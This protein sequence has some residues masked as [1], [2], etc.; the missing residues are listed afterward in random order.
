MQDTTSNGGISGITYGITYGIRGQ[1][2]RNFIFSLLRKGK[3]ND[4]YLSYLTDDEAMD[5]YAQAFTNPTANYSH[6]YEMLEK[7]GDA[8]CNKV[9]VWF[10][11]NKF[12][13]LNLKPQGVML[14]S[15]I[16]HVLRSKETFANIGNTL[17]FERFISSGLMMVKGGE[18]KRVMHV[19]RNSVVED[20]FE[21][22]IGATEL[23][24][25]KRLRE[26]VGYCI[27]QNI[28]TGLLNEFPFPS[29]RYEDLF[30]PIT[31]LKEL[32]DFQKFLFKDGTIGGLGS[33]KYLDGPY[34]EARQLKTVMI[35]YTDKR[36]N[37][38]IISTAQGAIKDTAKEL[39]A[40]YALKFFKSHGFEKSPPYDY[41]DFI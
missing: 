8:S 7:L 39:V 25:N 31:R 28:I 10:I 17:G 30:D 33:F 21:A 2:F 12:P 1:E 19:K 4:K 27:V 6:N 3:L 34:D 18:M 24:I 32:F 26:G 11:Y 40:D 37:K 35:E 14:I 15:R 13:K 38:S 20:C 22:F 9:I 36:G 29:I 16:S 23:L 5:L 41:R